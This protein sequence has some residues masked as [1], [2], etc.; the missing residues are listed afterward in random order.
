MWKSW[1]LSLSWILLCQQS[2][3]D[4]LELKWG[5]YSDWDGKQNKFK[6]AF[7]A[8]IQVQS[9]L[10]KKSTCLSSCLFQTVQIL[11]IIIHVIP[12]TVK[13]LEYFYVWEKPFQITGCMIVTSLRTQ[14]PSMI[15]LSISRS[16]N[17]VS[18]AEKIALWKSKLNKRLSNPSFFFLSYKC[19]GETTAD[20]SKQWLH[21][22]LIPMVQDM[23][24]CQWLNG[25]LTQSFF[26]LRKLFV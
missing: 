16:C 21:G 5:G 1:S 4:G 17:A 23:C 13:L 25:S 6:A 26:M 20:M 12:S 9:P 14:N 11:C 7:W 3:L 19:D 2:A 18:A 24:A 22:W 10:P 15:L 8:P